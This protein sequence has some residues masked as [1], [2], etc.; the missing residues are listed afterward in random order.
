MLTFRELRDLAERHGFPDP[1]LAAA[2]AMA[3]SGGRPDAKGDLD[4]G[5]S[6]GLWQINL[7]AHPQWLHHEDA[8]LDPD[9]NAQAAFQVSDGG[10]NW[11]PWTTY[12]TGA[13]KKYMPTAPTDPAPVSGADETDEYPF[14]SEDPEDDGDDS[15][16]RLDS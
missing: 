15:D 1:D 8:L 5:V 2:V 12:R 9:F 16:G 4:L 6:L 11:K 14:V 3:E 13:F 10:T 7:R